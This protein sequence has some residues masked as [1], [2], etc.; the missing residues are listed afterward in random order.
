MGPNSHGQGASQ[1]RWLARAWTW[2]RLAP[3]GRSLFLVETFSIIFV[4]M[5]LSPAQEES[6][7]YFSFEHEPEGKLRRDGKGVAACACLFAV[8]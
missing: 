7:V 4:V 2:S 5:I 3:S 6:Q 8:S 1:G